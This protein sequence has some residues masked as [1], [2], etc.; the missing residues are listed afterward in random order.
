[1]AQATINK[2]CVAC[3]VDCADKPR[4]KDTRGNYFCKPCFDDLLA[5]K[6]RGEKI[7][8]PRP[9]AGPRQS[10]DDDGLSSLHLPEDS[11]LG[12]LD[13]SASA[14][15]AGVSAPPSAEACAG[16]GS[17]LPLGSVLCVNCG[18]RADGGGKLRTAVQRTPRM[19][20]G[21]TDGTLGPVSMIFAIGG[22]VVGAIGSLGGLVTI[23]A[24]LIAMA[25]S[26]G[27]ALI[28][29]IFGAFYLWLGSLHLRGAIDTLRRSGRGPERMRL[30]SG[31]Y[32]G[33]AVVSTVAQ[34]KLLSGEGAAEARGDVSV[35]EM[36]GFAIVG[37]VIV[38]A[39]PIAVLAWTSIGNRSGAFRGWN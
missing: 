32:I 36:I 27:V 26:V 38:C 28:G 34:V 15:T 19:P 20:R 5:R 2:T 14:S 37:L 1:M 25:A 33:L 18:R 24:G 30:S 3:G 7:S 21:G 9:A 16:C 17:V 8:L 23:V 13:L 22:I 35:Q 12:S 4:T 29:L 6:E 10:T 31:I 39:W 11:L